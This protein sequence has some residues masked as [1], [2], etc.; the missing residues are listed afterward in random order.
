MESMD[1]F[2][3]SCGSGIHKNERVCRK[4][5]SDKLWQKEDKKPTKQ[6]SSSLGLRAYM[7]LLAEKPTDEHIKA[8]WEQIEL[9]KVSS[10]E[11]APKANYYF[12]KYSWKQDMPKPKKEDFGL[13]SK[14]KYPNEGDAANEYRLSFDVM[15][16]A[17][18]VILAISIFIIGMILTGGYSGGW[19]FLSLLGVFPTCL[20]LWRA[21]V[22][23]EPFRRLFHGP[24]LYNLMRYELVHAE[25][26]AVIGDEQERIE[27]ELALKRAKKTARE[28]KEKVWREA[29]AKKKA[30]HDSFTGKGNY[31]PDARYLLSILD[32]KTGEDLEIIVLGILR[33]KGWKVTLT[34]RGA[35]GGVDL[36]GVRQFR[37]RETKV[38]VQVKHWAAKVTE[39]AV[40]DFW[41]ASSGIYD[42]ALF[43]TSSDFNEPAMWFKQERSGHSGTTLKYWSGSQLQAEIDKLTNKTFQEM[44]DPLKTKLAKS[45][46]GEEAL[47]PL[48]DGD[49]QG[50]PVKRHSRG[51][52]RGPPCPLCGSAM[53][54]R[55][56]N[57][58][59][60]R[61]YGC[62]NYR[63]SGCKGT[64]NKA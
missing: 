29:L 37:N 20:I 45:V 12:D 41:G 25:Y 13:D 26:M 36:E 46:L 53:A 10:Q 42:E 32:S 38:A 40:R 57:S 64:I 22:P 5:G 24:E 44:I 30:M 7:K 21:L 47:S 62:V 9:N 3:W 8:A 6:E 16:L 2:C 52:R 34:G 33:A 54:I 15:A 27:K 18:A 28:A 55:V 11:P 43:V 23:R 50:D 59:E 31:R 48:L 14:V 1:R 49:T 35:D 17:A 39:K 4:C 56:N 51:R 60:T 58:D 19:L 61:F 63:S